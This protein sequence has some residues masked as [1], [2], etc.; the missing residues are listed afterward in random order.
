MVYTL[1]SLDY[2][3]GFLDLFR[4]RENFTDAPIRRLGRRDDGQ[5]FLNEIFL[6]GSGPGPKPPRIQSGGV[7]NQLGRSAAPNLQER[8]NSMVTG[9]GQ[10]NVVYDPGPEQFEKKLKLER[11]L[12]F[13]DLDIRRQQVQAQLENN[14]ILNAA[15][16]QNADANT[17]RAQ[18]AQMRAQNPNLIFKMTPEGVIALDP[19]TGQAINT[20]ISSGMME[21]EDEINLR[22]ENAMNLQGL[23]N[24]GAMNVA[25]TRADSAK[26]LEEMKQTG[27][28]DRLIQTLQANRANT[29]FKEGSSTWRTRLRD[30]DNPPLGPVERPPSAPPEINR[31]DIRST[32]GGSIGTVLSPGAINSLPS[33]KPIASHEDTGFRA[34]PGQFEAT[35]GQFTAGTTDAAAAAKGLNPQE[36]RTQAA[37]FLKANGKAVTEESIERAVQM[38]L[39]QQGQSGTTSGTPQG[40]PQASAAPSRYGTVTPLGTRLQH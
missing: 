20:G 40:T 33:M 7:I 32:P 39:Q 3:M 30:T 17:M 21:K 8:V 38:L 6:R 12:G 35:P 26:A 13:G 24:E 34:K 4:D 31:P 10:P 14:K 36:L 18:V 1:T 15:R 16:M 19:A 37:E 23:R 25:G 11:E 5:A 29:I 22:G 27:A 9:S 2:N 28:L